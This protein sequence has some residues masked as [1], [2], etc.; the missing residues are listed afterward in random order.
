MLVYCVGIRG[1]DGFDMAPDGGSGDRPGAGIPPSVLNSVD[2]KVLNAFSDASGGRAW[3]VGGGASAKDIEP[4]LDR[5]AEE[6][7]GQY[8]IGYYP[9]HPIKDGKW[10]N[11]RV[12]VTDPHYYARARKEYLGK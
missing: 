3:E 1:C 11:V 6:L 5:I 2:M 4:I 10:H 12:R 9:N 8:S 7:R